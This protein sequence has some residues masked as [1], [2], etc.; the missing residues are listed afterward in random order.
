MVLLQDHK[1]DPGEIL[2]WCFVIVRN[3]PAA[4]RVGIAA[5]DRI[6]E[7]VTVGTCKF[8]VTVWG[9]LDIKGW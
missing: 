2:Q 1:A 5:S 7:P 9:I 4:H 8:T 6:R 3:A